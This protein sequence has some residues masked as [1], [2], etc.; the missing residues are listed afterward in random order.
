MKLKSRQKKVLLKCAEELNELSTEL[1]QEVNKNKCR[2]NAI[3]LE[4]EDV[5][6]RLS[7][8]KDL[9]RPDINYPNHN[10]TELKLGDAKDFPF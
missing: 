3:C 8:L 4:V 5:E 7:D 2:Y 9:L 6:A 10:P 1:L